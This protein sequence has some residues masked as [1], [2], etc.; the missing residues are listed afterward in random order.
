MLKNI[1]KYFN[2]SNNTNKVKTKYNICLKEIRLDAK[3]QYYNLK[4]K[5]DHF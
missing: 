4:N 3:Q 2:K 1:S 5:K